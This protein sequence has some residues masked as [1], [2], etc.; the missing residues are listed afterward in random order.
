MARH[1]A[2]NIVAAGIAD[3]LEVQLAYAIGIPHPVSIMV[4]AFNTAKISEDKIKELIQ[5]HF[6]L[7]PRKM[8][9]SL[10]LLR[11]IYKNTAAYGHFGRHEE[12]FT[13]E[14]TDK[15][16]ALKRDAGL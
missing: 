6:E 11:P 14:K 12:E 4:D 15:A 10:D 13:W 1:I 16:E 7:R 9:Q 5:G 3:K 2:K 8:I